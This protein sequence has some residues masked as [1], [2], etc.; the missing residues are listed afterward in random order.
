MRAVGSF[1]KASSEFGDTCK[2][3]CVEVVEHDGLREAK[4]ILAIGDDGNL[5]EV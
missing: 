5:I 3:L 4:D 2:K 1:R